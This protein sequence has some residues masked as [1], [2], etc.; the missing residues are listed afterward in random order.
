M[1]A[2]RAPSAWSSRANDSRMQRDLGCDAQRASARAMRRGM[3]PHAAAKEWATQVPA[4]RLSARNPRAE[5]SVRALLQRW[6]S[7]PCSVRHCTLRAG[8]GPC[9]AS[10]TRAWRGRTHDTAHRGRGGTATC[11]RQLPAGRCVG[12]CGKVS[13]AVPTAAN[14]RRRI[15]GHGGLSRRKCCRRSGVD[16]ADRA[17]HAGARAPIDLHSCTHT[18]KPPA[19][20]GALDC[21]C[22][23]ARAV[24]RLQ[25]Q[26]AAPCK[27]TRP[28]DHD[29][30]RETR[31]HFARAQGL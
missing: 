13:G 30:S 15:V 10:D 28:R 6:A 23:E 29:T 18:D 7:V 14:H 20:Q 5:C 22:W 2:R 4:S 16:A 3:R 25:V 1:G 11:V 9:P 26:L 19:W 17:T 12:V 31:S 8:G 21:G 27:R 24:A